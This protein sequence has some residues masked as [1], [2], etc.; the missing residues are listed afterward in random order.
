MESSRA[1]SETPRLVSPAVFA[2]ATPS[3]TRVS[4]S[5]STVVNIVEDDDESLEDAFYLVGQHFFCK[6]C[7]DAQ[8][9]ALG[10]VRHSGRGGLGLEGR[11]VLKGTEGC[12][13]AHVLEHKKTADL[14]RTGVD[15]LFNTGPKYEH[16]VWAMVDGFVR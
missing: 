12:R 13:R 5:G 1:R 4:R 3:P 16:W 14:Q 2:P 15:K 11:Y 6:K 9:M 10:R 8:G 7:F